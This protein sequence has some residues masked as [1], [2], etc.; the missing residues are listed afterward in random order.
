MSAGSRAAHWQI[1]RVLN[2]NAVLARDRDA[3]QAVLLGRGIGY[4]RHLGDPVDAGSVSEVFVPDA[5]HSVPRLVSFLSETPLETVRLASEALEPV[6]AQGRVGVS[7]ALV[8]AVA[9]HLRFAVERSRAG[10]SVE[11]PLRWEVQQLYPEETR[12]GRQTVVLVGERLG[13]RLEDGEATTLALHLVNAQFAGSDLAP[14]VRMTRTITQILG[15]VSA[16]L[17]IQVDEQAMSTARFATHLRYLFVRLEDGRQISDSLE[18]LV[19][20]IRRAQPLAFR[21]ATRVRALLELNGP[22]LTDAEL[23]YLTLHIARLASECQPR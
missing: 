19:T 16:V 18:D 7:Q 4:G 5:D 23:A 3:G 12:W 20:P 15:V 2:N 9:D 13:V 8:L 6:R 10:I 11:H 21:A 17:G 22:R 1:V 14:T